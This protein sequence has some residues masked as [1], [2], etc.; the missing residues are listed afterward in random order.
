MRCTQIMGL[1]PK[2][3]SFLAD[4]LLYRKVR[5]GCPDC[6]T[7]HVQDACSEVYKDASHLG[8][9]DD[10]P[11]L[12]KHMLKDGTQVYEY[13]QGVPWS[14]GPMIFLALRSEDGVP[15]PETLWDEPL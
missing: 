6:R 5:C 7:E 15:I 12:L 8:M 4:R 10:G 2:A 9:F 13:V 11:E 1:S 14:S 3:R